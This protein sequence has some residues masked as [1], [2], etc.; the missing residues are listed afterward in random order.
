MGCQKR[1]IL[2]LFLALLSGCGRPAGPAG[3]PS[4]KVRLVCWVTPEVKQVEGMKD[5]TAEFGDYEK[6]QAAEYMQ[7]HP[8]VEIEVQSLASEDLTRKVTTAIAAGNPPDILKDFLGRTAGYAH[9]DL[10]E[11]FLPGLPPDELNDYEPFYRKLYTV[12]GQLHGLPCYAWAIHVVAN[13][14]VWEAA[15]K[16]DLLPREGDGSWTYDQFMAAMRAVARPN[17]VWPWWAQFASEQGDYCNYGFF[18]G[19]GAFMYPP[20]DYSK[21]TLNTPGGVAA[22]SLLTR[23]SRE[24]LIPPG[25]VTMPTS[26]LENM[27][28]RGEVAAWGDSL[29]AFHRMDIARK[30]GRL[31][32]PVKLQ[33][34]QYPHEEGRKAPMPVGPTGFVVFRQPDARKRQAAMDFARWLNRPETQRVMCANVRQFP[35]RKSTGSP[36]ENDPNYR[37]VKKWMDESGLVDLGLTSPAYYRVRVAAVPHLQA[38]ILGQKTAADALRDFETEANAIV[39][40]AP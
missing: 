12:N 21:V 7:A 11:D 40:Q 24:G 19:K 10:L 35:T 17:K 29:Y 38:A 3:P 39:K 18:W 27:I 1:L 9:Q 31:K 13:R 36:L 23:M 15:G 30:E 32:V 8:D 37:L 25:S 16:A 34:L 5:R 14:A 22:L 6:I 4:G 2:F 28:G 20:G 26:E 33:V